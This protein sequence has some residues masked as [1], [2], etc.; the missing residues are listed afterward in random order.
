MISNNDNSVKR[1]GKK[2]RKKKQEEV[3]EGEHNTPTTL[4][5]NSYHIN[6]PI[7]FREIKNSRQ[8]KKSRIKKK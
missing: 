8:K 4:K 7:I 6:H 3:R 5:K 1:K 2:M